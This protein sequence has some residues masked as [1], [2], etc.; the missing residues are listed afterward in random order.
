MQ[1]RLVNEEAGP[2]DLRRRRS[3]EIARAWQNFRRRKRLSQ[4]KCYYPGMSFLN[5]KYSEVRWHWFSI[6]LAISNRVADDEFDE[7][8]E[9]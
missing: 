7:T 8:T 2:P 4:S 9:N 6:Y 1:I 3:V 5:R